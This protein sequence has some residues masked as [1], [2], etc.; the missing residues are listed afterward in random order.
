MRSRLPIVSIFALCLSLAAPSLVLAASPNYDFTLIA[1]TTGPFSNFS[2]TPTIS[3]SGVVAFSAGLDIG[4]LAVAVGSGGS[5]TTIVD[6]TGGVFAVSNLGL[7]A[8]PVINN[9][10]VVAFFGVLAATG[11]RGFFTGSGGSITTIA[12]NGTGS[13]F[14]TF[15][16]TPSINAAGTVAFQASLAAGGQGIFTGSGGST[17][18]I[19]TTSTNQLSNPVINDTGNVAFWERFGVLPGP[20][21][22]G[23]L[24]GAGGP[25]TTIVQTGS[26]FFLLNQVPS[27]N[28]AGTVAFGATVL[29]GQGIFAGNGEPTTKLVDD[30]GPFGGFVLPPSNFSINDAGELAFQ[31]GLDAGGSGIFTGAALANDTVVRTGDALFGSTVTDVGFFRGGLNDEGSLA[32]WASLADGRQ[33]IARADPLGAAVPEPVTMVLLLPALVALAGYSRVKSQRFPI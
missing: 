9:S 29:G 18:T 3:D 10:G 6:T 33:V 26:G 19:A 27:M 25:T 7:G 24:T 17:T 16:V 22:F 30:S 14:S 13:P 8:T 20:F 5:T 23:I 11:D 1:D 31:V 12:T 2:R 15:G 4:G 28:N 21:T 32:F